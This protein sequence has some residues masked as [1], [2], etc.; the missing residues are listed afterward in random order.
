ML[1]LETFTQWV[2]G[3]GH[4]TL[5]ALLILM[6]LDVLT[7]TIV[8]SIRPR[9]RKEHFLRTLLKKIL[10]WLMVIA[11]HQVDLVLSQQQTLRNAVA[12]VLLGNELFSIVEQ[13][14]K[15]GV[16]IPEPLRRA[17]QALRGTETEKPEKPEQAQEK[18][19]A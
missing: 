3:P 15:A 17:I 1:H 14:A 9:V 16:P 19:R 12:Y 2:L 13:M 4:P 5:P 8:Q 7:R 18:T 10:L 6:L 11:A